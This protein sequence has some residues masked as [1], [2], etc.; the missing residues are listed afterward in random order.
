MSRL[1][2][3]RKGSFLLVSLVS[4]RDTHKLLDDSLDELGEVESLVRLAVPDVF[5][6]D[7]NDLGIGLGVEMVPSLDENKL[8]LL[9]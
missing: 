7:G 6:E 8:E 4:A 3:E 5:T 2:D 9:V 1:E